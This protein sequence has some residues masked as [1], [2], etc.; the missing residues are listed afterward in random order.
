VNPDVS[1]VVPVY[2]NRSSVRELHRRVAAVLEAEGRSFELLFVDDACPDGSGDL[3]MAL[4]ED[5]PRISVLRLARNVGQH[6]AVLAGLDV[7]RG[8]RV[9]VMDADLQDPPE[10]LPLLLDRLDGGPAA[11]VFGARR[12]RYESATRL[13]TS[14]AF[15]RTL[16]LLAGVPKDAGM[17]LVM[18]RRMVD[19]LPA[20][21]GPRP[22]VVALIGATGLPMDAVPVA[23]TPRRE[24]GSAYRGLMRASVAASAL[25]AAA[26][27]RIWPSRHRRA[28]R[29]PVRSYR[30]ATELGPPVAERRDELPNPRRP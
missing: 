5:D 9:A 3:V 28:I 20:G 13:L 14:R 24:G 7:A 15:K 29:A 23:R 12:G 2:R 26:T 22:F 6:R 1:V 4:A 17:F 19:R 18:D 8:E 27:E 16:Q 25:R 11:A 10:A 30:P 21:A